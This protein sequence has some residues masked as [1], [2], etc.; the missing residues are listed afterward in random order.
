MASSPNDPSVSKKLPEDEIEAAPFT[1]GEPYF[2]DGNIILTVE[3]THF[4]VYR[5]V[6]AALSPVFAD[7]FA[8]AQPSTDETLVDGCPVIE[9][10]DSV[11]D[12]EILL[13]AYFQR[14]YLIT[15]VSVAGTLI[16]N[17]LWHSFDFVE[18]VPL[19]MS[20]VTAYLRL[21]TK[22]DM[23]KFRGQ[24]VKRLTYEFPSTL[25][26]LDKINHYTRIQE[27]ESFANNFFSVV[28]L[29]NRYNVPQILPWLF[30]A[31]CSH[32]SV[33]AMSRPTPPFLSRQDLQTCL[34]GREQLL[35]LQ[36]KHT[37]AWL[38]KEQCPSCTEL[39]NITRKNLRDTH[40]GPIP[41]CRALESWGPK[42]HTGLC[43]PC[44]V[45]ARASHEAGRKK[46]WDK[47]PSVFCLPDWP[48]LLKQ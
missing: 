11:E 3:R 24:A 1:R 47:L 32:L 41:T 30:Y 12:W 48:D 2:D 39:C 40:F 35:G 6:L 16:I 26:T 20:V 37:F 5:G 23:E 29:A 13:E 17:V 14:R 22:Y 27:C 28:D 4:R 25:Q 18:T 7:M 42:W 8:M 21:G 43:R 44:T 36:A 9:L 31:T 34:T 38:I 10:D 45:S 19:P 33:K 15:A 46:I